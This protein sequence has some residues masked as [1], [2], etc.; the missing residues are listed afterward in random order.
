MSKIFAD[1]KDGLVQMLLAT[2]IRTKNL[3]A[4][5]Q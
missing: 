3:A 1:E 2:L 5:N 4:T